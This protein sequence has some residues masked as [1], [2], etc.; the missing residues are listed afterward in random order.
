MPAYKELKKNIT[1][2]FIKNTTRSQCGKHIYC[3]M[4]TTYMPIHKIKSTDKDG[5]N[6]GRNEWSPV[7][8]IIM[9]E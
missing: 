5:G 8:E 2:I 6:S 9:Y 1:D 7:F 4:H 3:R